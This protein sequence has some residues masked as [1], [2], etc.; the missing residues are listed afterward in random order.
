MTVLNLTDRIKYNGN[1]ATVSFAYPFQILTDADMLAVVIS[2]LGVPTTLVLNDDYSVTGAGNVN[3]GTVVLSAGSLCPTGSTLTLLRDMDLTQETDYV[4]GQAFSAES[5]ELALDKTA[6]INQQLKEEISRALKL[7]AGST[8]TLELPSDDRASKLLGFGPTGSPALFETGITPYLNDRYWEKV[9]DYASLTAAIAAIGL[10]ETDL[11]IDSDTTCTGNTT[12]PANIRI[13][14]TRKGSINQGAFTLTLNGPF[15]AGLHQAFSGTG[16]IVFGHGVAP[17]VYPQWW[18]A[19]ADWDGVTGTDCTTAIQNALASLETGGGVLIQTG[20]MKI[21][22]TLTY[23]G[24]EERALYW[25][26][27]GSKP[28]LVWD[29]DLGGTMTAF[30]TFNQSNGLVRIEN[31]RFTSSSNAKRAGLAVQWK[32]INES[33]IKWCNF[34]NVTNAI[35]WEFILLSEI[36]FCRFQ[37]VYNDAIYVGGNQQ[38]NGCR[39][40]NCEFAMYGRYAIYFASSGGSN[41]NLIRH[42]D[43]EGT[44]AGTLASILLEDFTRG[45]L[46][47]NRFEDISFANDF[48]SLVISGCSYVYLTGNTFGEAG[49]GGHTGIYGI[50]IKDR[51]GIVSNGIYMDKNIVTNI[52][53][54]YMTSTGSYYSSTADQ[55]TFA[56]ATANMIYRYNWYETMMQTDQISLRRGGGGAHG[57]LNGDSFGLA[58]KKLYR[59]DGMP[60]SG[61]FVQGDLVVKSNFVVGQPWG[62]A[63]LTTGSGHVLN[64]DWASMGNL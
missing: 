19:K 47:Y 36:T 8:G 27:R 50:E 7:P 12:V 15:E 29:G 18:G 45:W 1:G 3:G 16:S 23:H 56:G 55:M 51:G 30:G 24:T 32:S 62:W 60:T 37:E 33:S 38:T 2:S 64:T 54:V 5:V 9:S 46:E 63:R 44:R 52:G 58:G 17:Y 21:T 53:G 59:L 39:I 41:G 13:M 25:L 28:F 40:E 20:P 22:A 4:D 42:N 43:F 31:I 14:I 48:R 26:G 11:L 10:A 6:M 61:S 35:N 49:D 57:D 34:L